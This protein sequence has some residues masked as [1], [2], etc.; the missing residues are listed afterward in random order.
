MHALWRPTPA[1]LRLLLPRYERRAF[2]YPH[3]GDTRRATPPGYR[4]VNRSTGLG[5]GRAVFRAAAK[6]LLTWEMHRRAGALVVASD[7]SARA[8][9]TVLQALGLGPVAV[10]A[11]CRVVYVLREPSQ[12]G[13]AY[14]TLPGHP[15]SGEEA[16]VVRLDAAGAVEFTVTAFSRPGSA[17]T[18]I[19]APLAR[20]V[21]DWMTTRYL[22]AMKTL[23]ADT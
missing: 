16:F 2:S 8:G 9:T 14:G 20:A 4:R 17:L 10:M 15:E 23:V 22:Q 21:Q 6:A 5:H 3:V 13:F 12:M 18:H 7:A 11:P 1:A 19:A